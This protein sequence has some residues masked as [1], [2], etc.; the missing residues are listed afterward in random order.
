MIERTVLYK[1]KKETPQEVFELYANKMN[2]VQQE[3]AGMIQV[4]FGTATK[5]GFDTDDYNFVC[6]AK[7][8]DLDSIEQ[9]K[10]NNHHVELV[11]KVISYLDAPVKIIFHDEKQIQSIKESV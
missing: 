11:Q 7:F 3:V 8:T 4:I 9:Y 10:E 1:F 5:M 2:S 6:S